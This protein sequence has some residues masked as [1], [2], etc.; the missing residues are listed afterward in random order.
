MFKTQIV[1][2]HRTCN[3]NAEPNFTPQTLVI[4]TCDIGSLFVKNAPEQQGC[5]NGVDCALCVCVGEGRGGLWG[6][7]KLC[8]QLCCEPKDALKNKVY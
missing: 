2:T 8:T 6:L 1:K 5:D 4:M 3:T 7:S